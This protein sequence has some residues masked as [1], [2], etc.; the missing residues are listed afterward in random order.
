LKPIL[1]ACEAKSPKLASIS[2]MSIQKLVAN[3]LVAPDDMPP[4][5]HGI[6]QA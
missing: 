1:M 2:L 6:E 5:L 4:L 3:D